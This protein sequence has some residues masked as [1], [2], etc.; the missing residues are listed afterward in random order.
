VAT[1]QE[2]AA[3]ASEEA[4][5]KVAIRGRGRMRDGDHCSAEPVRFEGYTADEILAWPVGQI[6][7]LVVRDEVLVM[8]IGS[9]TVL[10]KFAIRE[11]RLVVEL[12]QI[13][14][15]GEGVLLALGSM[16]RR[17]ARRE[18]L[19]A[20]EWIVHAVTCAKPNEKLR[21]VLERRGFVVRRLDGVGEAYHFVDFV[22]E[23][24]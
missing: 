4:R 9:A 6:R 11:M 23:S 24:S 2:P 15:G 17:Y 22:R 5:V 7:A 3:T 21:R 18:E 10:G 16:A 13:E 1:I 19:E 12:A 20:V 8:R 14:E